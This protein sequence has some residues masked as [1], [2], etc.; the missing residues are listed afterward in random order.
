MK[1][2]PEDWPGPIEGGI[3]KSA[4]EVDKGDFLILWRNEHKEAAEITDRKEGL[5]YYTM[6]NGAD[7]G[8]KFSAHFDRTQMV[9]VFKTA[10]EAIAESDPDD[11]G[12][13]SD[14]TE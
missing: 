14:E 13:D 12:G 7:K 9:K 8:T 10:D 11:E 5:V 3:R 1:N 4:S 2:Q 6:L